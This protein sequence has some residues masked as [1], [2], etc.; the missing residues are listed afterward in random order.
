[1]ELL[2]YPALYEAWRWNLQA[3]PALRRET[4]AIR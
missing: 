1:L 4:A 2:V 3:R